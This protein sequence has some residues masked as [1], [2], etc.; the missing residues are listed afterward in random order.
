MR[1]DS[2]RCA[3]QPLRSGGSV[4]SFFEID[5]DGRFDCPGVRCPEVLTEVVN[6]TC[7]LYQRKGFVRP[8]IGYLAVE[9]A[10]AVGS[11][12]FNGPMRDGRAEIA[13]FTFPG[14]EGRGIATAMADYLLQRCA[15]D[16]SNPTVLAHTL[17]ETNA[18]TS[19]L[20]KLGFRCSGLVTLAEDGDVFEWLRPP[21]EGERPAE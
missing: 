8:W 19:I 3:S 20:R 11:C 12:G 9:E 14:N 2:L 18:S 15:D 4:L 7:A 21:G 5:Q 16:P 17:P 6:A 1:A 13:Y 10:V